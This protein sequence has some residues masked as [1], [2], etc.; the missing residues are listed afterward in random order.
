MPP[1]PANYLNIIAV[2]LGAESGPDVGGL[3]V[4]ANSCAAR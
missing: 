2:N 1:R 4:G 3:E